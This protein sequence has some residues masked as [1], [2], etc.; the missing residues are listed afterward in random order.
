MIPRS[1][2]PVIG[3]PEEFA[4]YVKADSGKW[5]KVIREQNLKIE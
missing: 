3:S 4:A 5:L 1:L 2:E